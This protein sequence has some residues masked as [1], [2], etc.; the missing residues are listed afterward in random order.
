MKSKFEISKAVIQEGDKYLLIKRFPGSKSYP[1][2]WDF[3]GGKSEPGEGPAESVVRET[4]EEIALDIDPGSEVKRAKYKDEEHSLTFHY[5]IP[6]AIIGKVKLSHDHTEYRWVGEDDIR[7]LE[8]HPS[9]DL[10]FQE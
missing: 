2:L 7:E 5:F 3:P 1:N 6:K 9:V 10:F 8:L 4:K